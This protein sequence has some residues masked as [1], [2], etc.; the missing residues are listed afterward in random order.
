[1][2]RVNLYDPVTILLAIIFVVI[3]L[4]PVELLALSVMP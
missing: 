3:A 1:M 4:A 2:T